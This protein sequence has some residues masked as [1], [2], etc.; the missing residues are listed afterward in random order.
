MSGPRK[1]PREAPPREATRLESDDEIRQALFSRRAG[2]KPIPPIG[3]GAPPPAVL[4]AVLDDDPAPYRPQLRPPMAVLCVLDDG[5]DEG[6]WIRLRG[7]RF[8]IGR[9]EGDLRIPHD[10]M[11]S[12]RHAEIS[13]QQVQGAY[14]WQITDLE[15]TNGTYVRVGN[16]L[17]KHG[18]E[19]RMGRS[20]FR[21]EAA[22]SVAEAETR[23]APAQQGTLSWQGQP[24]QQMVAALVEIVRGGPGTRHAL[25]QA[26]YWIGRDSRCGIVPADDPFL[27]AQHARIYRDAKGQWHVENNKSR[28][29]LWARIDQVPVPATCH[30]Q[31]GEQRFLLK[32]LT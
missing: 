9:T 6:E 12:G 11:M 27:N 31:L 24:V 1:D 19:L 23:A 26:E 22:Q 14:R 30:F 15:S 32:V 10:P 2:R 7:D 17:L 21:F 16:V 3:P 13:R 18:Q 20:H 25:L 5:K 4:D 29:G 28:N 8:V